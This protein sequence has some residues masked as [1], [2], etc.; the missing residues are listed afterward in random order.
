[1]FSQKKINIIFVAKKELG[2]LHRRFYSDSG[3]GFYF[4]IFS[5]SVF[6]ADLSGPNRPKLARPVRVRPKR[7]LYS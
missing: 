3:M 7:P 4:R 2:G 6:G 5:R 1:M